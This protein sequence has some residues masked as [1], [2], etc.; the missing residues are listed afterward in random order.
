MLASAP[1]ENAG[2]AGGAATVPGVAAIS[3]S[4]LLEEFKHAFQLRGIRGE[5]GVFLEIENEAGCSR[6]NSLG[7]RIVHNVLVFREKDGLRFA[8]A[9]GDG[10]AESDG[11]GLE[12]GGVG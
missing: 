9:G 3:E 11:C 10:E 12:D 8:L 7:R 1:N 6:R 4:V 5:V 2:G